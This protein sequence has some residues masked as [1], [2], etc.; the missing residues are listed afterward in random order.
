VEKLNSQIKSLRFEVEH[1]EKLVRELDLLLQR[2]IIKISEAQCKYGDFNQTNN[3]Q[4]RAQVDIE[5]RS[6]MAMET[7]YSQINLAASLI[8]E[9]VMDQI[10]VMPRFV[11]RQQQLLKLRH[12][13]LKLE[14]EIQPCNQSESS[15]QQSPSVKL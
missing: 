15:K 5:E 4:F 11:E 1:G 2:M 6:K 7:V 14:E 8:N 12:D 3:E 10:E 9:W 13:S